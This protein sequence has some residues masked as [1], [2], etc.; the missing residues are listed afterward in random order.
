[1]PAKTAAKRARSKTSIP[2][3]RPDMPAVY[4]PKDAKPNFVP[5]SFAEQRLTR[6]HNYWVCSTRP[7]GRPHSAPVW[8]IW[9][10]GAFY[11]STDPSSRKGKNMNAN[12]A[13][14]IHVESGD[15]PVILEGQI[16]VVQLDKRIDAA[17][18]RKYRMHLIGF[19]GPVAVYR[20]KPKTVL[21]WREKDFGT[22][23]TKWEF[24]R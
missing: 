16:E 2:P 7:D 17:Y 19:P 9:L 5:W 10:D 21:A 8:G 12:P 3:M 18:H 11:F 22:S 23:A 4:S 1:M 24:G 6:S 14:S 20:L 13:V 15:E